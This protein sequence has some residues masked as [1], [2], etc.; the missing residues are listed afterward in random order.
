MEYWSTFIRSFS[1][2][3][4][5]LY[6]WM[7]AVYLSF[8]SCS[9]FVTYVKIETNIIQRCVTFSLPIRHI[10]KLYM[11]FPSRNKADEVPLMLCICISPQVFN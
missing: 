9:H 3:V 1:Y 6:R 10:I 5:S 8:E 4:M 2:Q 7:P 11:R